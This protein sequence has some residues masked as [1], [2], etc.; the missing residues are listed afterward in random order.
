MLSTPPTKPKMTRFNTGAAADVPPVPTVEKRP[1]QSN[2]KKNKNRKN[3]NKKQRKT[4]WKDIQP[5]LDEALGLLPETVKEEFEDGRKLF[6]YRSTFDR[7]PNKINYKYP[8]FTVRANRLQ[9]DEYAN[10]SSDANCHYFNVYHPI[11]IEFPYP[12]RTFGYKDPLMSSDRYGSNSIAF[13]LGQD[14]KETDELN[15]FYTKAKKDLKQH[16]TSLQQAFGGDDGAVQF[17]DLIKMPKNKNTEEEKKKLKAIL[18]AK[19]TRRSEIYHQNA[20]NTPVES[21]PFRS[22]VR[23]ML[24]FNG[25]KYVKGRKMFYPDLKLSLLHICKDENV[26]TLQKSGASQQS[27]GDKYGD[28][29]SF[30]QDNEKKNASTFA[31]SVL[32]KGFPKITDHQPDP[33]DEPY[34]ENNVISRFQSLFAKPKPKYRP[35]NLIVGSSLGK[36]QRQQQGKEKRPIQRIDAKARRFGKRGQDQPGYAESMFHMQLAKRR[37]A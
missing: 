9:K 21:V 11:L 3:K 35:W 8:E 13:L 36:Q 27:K 16:V 17:A 18:T 22:L 29:F 25:F 24:V 7:N 12:L 4:T 26:E 33:M 30:Q 19:I 34:E 31:T 5:T 32:E 20:P 6:K 1:R 15:I 14:W 28:L 2:K 10:F 37:Y 23:V